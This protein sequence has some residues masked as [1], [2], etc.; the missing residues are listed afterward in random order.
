MAISSPVFDQY[1]RLLHPERPSSPMCSSEDLRC[2]R[3]IRKSA[4][5][6]S[7]FYLATSPSFNVHEEDNTKKDNNPE[8]VVVEA[9]EDTSFCSEPSS[10]DS[11]EGRL[12]F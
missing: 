5:K 2:M 1:P 3:L 6:P 4:Q 11:D 10:S 12:Q 8:V 9:E 7:M